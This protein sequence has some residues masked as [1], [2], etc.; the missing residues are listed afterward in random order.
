MDPLSHCKTV[1]QVCNISNFS[2]R[3]LFGGIGL[4]FR[5]G[6][7]KLDEEHIVF[8]FGRFLVVHEVFSGTQKFS[9][10]FEDITCIASCPEGP[11]LAVAEAGATPCILLVDGLT[12]R[13]R[14]Q[15]KPPSG[16]CKV[17]SGLMLALLLNGT[18]DVLSSCTVHRMPGHWFSDGGRG[19]VTCKCGASGAKHTVNPMFPVSEQKIISLAISASGKWI[20]ALAW[21]GPN[22]P[23]N[24]IVWAADRSRVVVDNVQLNEPEA[25]TLDV[26]FSHPCTL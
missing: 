19:S 25:S 2:F 20:A 12:L 15:L 9:A 22:V 3:Q 17:C 18:S 7:V 4:S 24:L 16:Q 23:I 26:S 6:V 5:H 10:P 21:A 1:S 13:R 11:I 8:P 14:K